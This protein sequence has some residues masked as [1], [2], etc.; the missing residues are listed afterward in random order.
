MCIKRLEE[1]IDAEQ[2]HHVQPR[3]QPAGG[4]LDRP[5]Q[6]GWLNEFAIFKPDVVDQ[7]Q[8][9]PDDHEK[10]GGVREHRKD[11]A[12]GIDRR[13]DE[14]S[15]QSI[16]AAA[17][18]QF[19]KPCRKCE[20]FIGMR[21]HHRVDCGDSTHQLLSWELR[22][23]IPDLIDISIDLREPCILPLLGVDFFLLEF[24]FG[25][26]LLRAELPL[27]GIPTG[28][29]RHR[30]GIGRLRGRPLAFECDPS[31]GLARLAVRVGLAGRR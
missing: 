13:P 20:Y 18:L 16:P 21:P 19:I 14:I 5:F 6:P 29:S 27:R 23:P 8:I 31:I 22:Q 15:G 24:Q 26:R 11:G 17:T 4:N 30:F 25:S 12:F 28:R 9:Q 2:Y 1:R 10:E 7:S 3:M